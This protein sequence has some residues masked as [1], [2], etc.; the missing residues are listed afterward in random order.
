MKKLF[1]I[2]IF[3]L[4]VAL[5]TFSK[6]EEAYVSP[7]EIS[8]TMKDGYIEGNTTQK[9]SVINNYSYNVSVTAWMKHPD[10]SSDMRTSRTFIENLSWI[11][12]NPSKQIIPVDGRADFYINITI[13][14]EKQNESLGKNW[15]TWAALKIDDASGYGTSLIDVGYLI[16]VYTDTP[17]LK[18]MGSK[19]L[20]LYYTLI[21]VII[22]LVSAIVFLLFKKKKGR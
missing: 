2:F 20:L 11:T 16:R 5:S 1:T 15:E 8:I 18:V 7:A 4:F 17:P 13:P 21:A 12:I 6:A 14:K 3:A 9:I 22:A 10:P 19:N